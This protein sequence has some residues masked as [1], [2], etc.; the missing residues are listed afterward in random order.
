[1]RRLRIGTDRVIVWSIYNDGKEYD[2][3]EKDLTLKVSAPG[4]SFFVDKDLVIEGNVLQWTFRGRDQKALGAYS[5]TLIENDGKEGM[6]SFDKCNAFALVDCS[7]KEGGTDD[8]NLSV[9]G[10]NLSSDLAA[11]GIQ[12]LTPYVGQN[13]NWWINGIDTG[14]PA[15]A[16]LELNLKVDKVEGKGL[17]TNDYTD[18]DKERVSYGGAVISD[19]DSLWNA[20]I[21]GSKYGPIVNFMDPDG[22][23][24]L[25]G[26]YHIVDFSVEPTPYVRFVAIVS[27]DW[28][29]DTYLMRISYNRAYGNYSI[30]RKKVDSILTS[31]QFATQAEIDAIFDGNSAGTSS[32]Y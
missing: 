5:L 13:G 18:E 21:D 1:M 25:N 22:G 16:T 19:E 26:V 15:D 27:D 28:T 30:T 9:S 12:V 29:G 31:E 6:I 3:S 7:C 8:A 23:G 4:M 24:E 32:S 20:A 10:V 11:I 2:I 14:L 17:S